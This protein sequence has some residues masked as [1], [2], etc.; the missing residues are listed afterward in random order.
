MNRK[1]WLESRPSLVGVLSLTLGLTLLYAIVFVTSEIFFYDDATGISLSV[2]Y[3]D[4]ETRDHPQGTLYSLK[5]A[6]NNY[7]KGFAAV[8]RIFW[9]LVALMFCGGGIL[10]E[11]GGGTASFNLSL[12]VSRAGWLWRKAAMVS[13]LTLGTAFLTSILAVLI[14]LWMGL[15]WSLVWL[16]T[17]PVLITVQALPWIGFCLYVQSWTFEVVSSPTYALV[18][19]AALTAAVTGLYIAAVIMSEIPQSWGAALS[20]FA[21][22]AACMLLATWRLERLDF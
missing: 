12:P 8:S 19:P 17:H 11:K 15:D 5:D 18:L 20:V 9:P 1:L 22:G 7:Y 6:P 13:F 3:G 21:V 2:G 14:G 4:D 10:L 16:L